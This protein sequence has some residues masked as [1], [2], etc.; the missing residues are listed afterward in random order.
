MSEPISET[1]YYELIKSIATEEFI[2]DLR[3]LI[4]LIG[5]EVDMQETVN[6]Y[7]AVC[8][9]VGKTPGRLGP[10]EVEWGT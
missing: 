7:E 1:E 3:C 5:W 9:V 2:L 10:A 8:R 4:E 6:F